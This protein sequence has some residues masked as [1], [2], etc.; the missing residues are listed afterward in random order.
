MASYSLKNYNYSMVNECT[1]GS[2]LMRKLRKSP[3][4]MSRTVGTLPTKYLYKEKE[5]L[6]LKGHAVTIPFTFILKWAAGMVQ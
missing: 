2:F 5:T 3:V 1:L 4:R 6:V